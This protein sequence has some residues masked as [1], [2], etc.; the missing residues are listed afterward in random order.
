M[1]EINNQFDDFKPAE[2]SYVSEAISKVFEK[3]LSEVEQFK[4]ELDDQLT[5][6]DDPKEELTNMI[7]GY[8]QGMGDVDQVNICSYDNGKGVALDAWGF[9]GDEEMTS[10]DLFL[11]VYADPEKGKKISANDLDRHFNWL[12]RFYEQSINGS[13]LQDRR[14]QKRPVSGRRPHP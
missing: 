3:E 1:D 9:N 5:L 11:T 13:M 2:A 12:V 6:A 7:I 8:I 14:H 10:I 4:E